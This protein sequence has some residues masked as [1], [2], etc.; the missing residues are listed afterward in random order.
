MQDLPAEYLSA[1]QAL[2][3]AIGERIRY[4]RLK[5]DITQDQLRARMEFE[6]VFLS[7]TQ[8]SR[9]ENGEVLPDAAVLLALHH[10]FDVPLDWIVKGSGST[11]Q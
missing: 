8:Y 6:N 10:I 5:L 2:A 9:I 1:K 4:R 7:R 3:Q 11:D